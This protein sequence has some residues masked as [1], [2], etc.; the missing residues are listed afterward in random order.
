[1]EAADAD[2]Q[3]LGGDLTDFD[4]SDPRHSR[5]SKL[6]P[7]I[8]FSHAVCRNAS[9]GKAFEQR[10]DDFDDDNNRFP[11]GITYCD[12]S[13][14][15]ADEANWP[16]LAPAVGRSSL[17]WDDPKSIVARLRTEVSQQ[18][19]ILSFLVYR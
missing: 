4:T 1:M 6:K 19:R 18:L 14:Y 9:C 17:T 5:P 2:A 13:C 7:Q 11:V 10:R 8:P 12:W 3:A 16:S 15:E